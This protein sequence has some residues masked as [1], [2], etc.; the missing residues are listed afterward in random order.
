MVK[1]FEDEI[2]HILMLNLMK[3]PDP[4]AGMTTPEIK[5]ELAKTNDKF[6]NHAWKKDMTNN[7]LR[8][9]REK[10]RV[11][12]FFSPRD[13]YTEVR[14]CAYPFKLA[15]I[16]KLV[17]DLKEDLEKEREQTR[18]VFEAN[19][20]K[21]FPYILE[22]GADLE[23]LEVELLGK[24][25]P[26]IYEIEIEKTILSKIFHIKNLFEEEFKKRFIEEQENMKK[27]KT[28]E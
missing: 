10:K 3:N 25:I 26:E 1:A 2:Y 8:V 23:L 9:L 4:T 18:Q 12:R 24:N 5:E 27:K 21:I 20:H 17:E 19:F 28:Q 16:T 11:F 22:L 15:T 6:R 14:H 13:N 7:A